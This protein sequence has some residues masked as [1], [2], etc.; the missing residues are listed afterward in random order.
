MNLAYRY[1]EKENFDSYDDFC[2]G[3]KIKV[4][5]SF[6]FA[7]DI[8][9]EYARLEPERKALVWCDDHGDEKTFTFLDLRRWSSKTANYLKSLG[10]KKGDRVMLILRR[11]YEF[12]FFA[13][14]LCRIG[15]VYIP[16]THQLKEKD[17]VYRANA[18]GAKMIVAYPSDG[19][20]DSVEQ[21]LDKSP[22]VEK[23]VMVGGKR[24]G[25]LCYDED[26]RSFPEEFPRPEGDEAPK[27]DDL[28]IIYFT[29]GTTSM[30]K[31]ACHDYTYP[32]GHIVTAKYWQRVVDYGLHLTVSDSGWAKFGWGKI[33]GQWICGAVQFVYDMDKF[34]PE[35]LL[36]V[37]EKY[38]LSTFCAPPTI[39][40]FLI[41]HD[42]EKYDLS[43]LVHCSTAGEPLNPQVFNTWEKITGLKIYNGF[44]QSETTVLVANWE[45]LD[46]HPGSM[47]MPN[48]AY[49]IDI[50]DEEGNPVPAG[51]EGELVIRDVD[52]NKPVGL[53]RGYYRDEEATRKVWHDNT[54]HTGDVV[55][56]DEYGLLW[57]VGRN[58]DVIKASGYRISPFEVES[59]LIEHPAV[60]ECAVTGAPDPIRGTVVKA[61]V[62]LAR[63]YKP[64]EELKKE[65][66]DYV[67]N[68][69][70]P[71]KYPRII[72]FVDELPKTISGKIKRAYIR[73]ADHGETVE[74]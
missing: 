67:K 72:D 70:A 16:C 46:I 44:G 34:V 7:Y 45:W 48:P 42:L 23:L 68:V 24:N 29:S 74:E 32:L 58:D 73:K 55:Y 27:N 69:T 11:R 21:A 59:A 20:I 54:Y 61:T 51:V 33:Y 43:S 52:T 17:I 3:L 9:D 64:S 47:G 25:W 14:A 28:M 30:P 66:Q 40:R 22:S 4:P 41:H 56:R 62:V 38:K 50:V 13:F 6:N 49:N 15:A 26:I 57:F 36:E 8:I 12:Y 53:F 39:Y 35:R 5:D 31:M 60:L 2:R 19:V 65:I 63:G 71:Y 18:A 1:L 37:M 10:I